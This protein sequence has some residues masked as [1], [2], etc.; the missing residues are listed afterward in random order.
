V[1]VQ[2]GLFQDG[3]VE[4]SGSGLHAGDQVVVAL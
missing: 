2:L 1:P 3:F 4:V